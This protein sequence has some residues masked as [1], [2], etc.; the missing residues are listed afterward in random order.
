MSTYVDAGGAIKEWVNSLSELVGS[1]HP[2]PLGASLTQRSGAASV[3]YAYL[4]ELPATVWGGTEHPS[5]LAR[6]SAQVYGPTKEAASDAAVAYAEA[7]MT[8]MQG[9]RVT[10]PTSG[11]TL[12]GA[13]NIDGPQWFP[14]GEEPRYIVDADFLFL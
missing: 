5:M 14:D 1:G 10:L 12:A 11:V 4:V 2:M 3:A 6:V 9:R 7:V 8:L 13:D